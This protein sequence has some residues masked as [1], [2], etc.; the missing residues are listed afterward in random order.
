MDRKICI[1]FIFCLFLPH[2]VWAGTSYIPVWQHGFG[3][4]Y[5]NSIYNNDT[6][7]IDTVVTLIDVVYAKTYSESM[8]I[9]PGDTWMFDSTYFGMSFGFG[10]GYITSTGA[11]KTTYSAGAVLGTI[12]GQLTGLTVTTLESGFSGT[13]YIPIWQHGFGVT[14]YN[15]MINTDTKTAHA[16]LNLIDTLSNSTFSST[17]DI[18]QNEVW[19]S[20]T[21]V[22]DGWY[23]AAGGP[24]YGFGWGFMTSDGAPGTTFSWGAVYGTIA[25]KI[26]GLTVLIPNTGF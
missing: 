20:N 23:Q 16:E 18:P 11:P 3:V 26:S 14:Y 4:Y 17:H 6:V 19:I 8:A 25:G 13:A 22:H 15:N 24:R 5:V 7:T 21:S 1:L 12:A 2:T 10:W 9:A